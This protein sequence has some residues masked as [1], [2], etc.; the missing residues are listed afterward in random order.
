MRNIE[1]VYYNVYYYCNILDNLL[2]L[3]TSSID[4]ASTGAQ[5]TEPFFEGEVENFSK[6]S[7]LHA[8]C[9]FAVRKLM[10]EEAE[11]VLERVQ[12]V[13]DGLEIE[14]KEQR[15]KKAFQQSGNGNCLLEVDRL[16][17]MYN[18]QHETFYE[19]LV[20]NDFD[21]ILDAYTDFVFLDGDLE[22]A[23]LHLS[24]EL[25]YV[26][27]QNREFLYRFNT[28]MAGANQL[29][30]QRCNIPWWVRRAVKYR[31]RGKC[32]CCGKD[33]SG[34]LD[35]EDEASVHYDHMVAL[36][37]GGLNDVSN[38][39]LMCRECNLK[40]SDDSYTGTSYKDWYDFED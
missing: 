35:C 36:H 25:F 30:S 14:D 31:D 17:R 27:F 2:H 11:G 24:R 9:D 40:K 23:M 21:F 26:L 32:V 8:F 16:F 29:V 15:L 19:Y 4:W 28:Y 13:Y 37:V 10:F 20:N 1:M 34:V 38:I 7:A 18:V 5:F 6:Y 33:L 22:D 39:Q 12:E 3:F